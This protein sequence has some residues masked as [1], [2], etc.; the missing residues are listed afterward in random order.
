MAAQG[1]PERARVVVIGGGVGGA[2]IVHHLAARGETDVVL[3]ERS[4]LTSGSTFHSAGLVG[5]LRSSVTLT[6]LMM[7]SASLY[8]DLAA[9]PETDPGWVECGGLRLAS[10]PERM[11]E[12][13][14]QVAWGETFGLHLEQ[15][16]AAQ[17]ADLFPLM[18]T[19]G[20]L[21]A[22]YLATDGYL[23]PS[24]LTYALV[25]RARSAGIGIHERT[26]V[27]GI[28]VGVGRFPAVRS[29][30]TDRG[31][32]ECEVVVAAAGLYT[33][34]IARMVGVRVPIVPMSHQYVVTA[35]FRDV[36][37]G[38]GAGAGAPRLPTVRDPD[39]LVY[40]RQDGAGL[41]MGG[42]ERMS[43][44]FALGP[45]GLDRV[46]ADFNGRL[47][48]EEWDRLEEITANSVTRVPVMGD[49]EIRRVINGPEG[50]TPD[51]E[52]CLGPTP[53]DGF[54]V[55]AGFCA[56]GIAGA[57]AVGKVMADWVVDGDPGM[58][59]WEMDARRFGPQYRS[60]GY[61]LARVRENYETYYD[62]RY[63]GQE[64]EA[65][66]P[67][68]T[69][70][71]YPWHAANGASFGEKSGWERVNYYT[72][73]AAGGDAG[74]RPA[75]WA[76]RLWS[77]AI[78]VEHRATRERAGLFDESSF[79]KLE[80][81]G[82]GAAAL[83]DRLCANWV[84]RGPGRVTYTQ[85]LNERGGIE[86]D[87]TVSQVDDRTFMVVT[88]TALAGHD[89]AWI[90][91]HARSQIA[92]GSVQVRDV[93]SQWVC[94]G[95]WGP[96]ARDIL[97][98]LTPASLD[99]DAFGYLTL[100]EAPVGNAP[101]RIVRVTF[102][103][104]L[105]WEI[106]APTEYGAALWEEIW[107]AGAEH[108]LTACGY[109]AIDSLRAEKGYRYWGSDITGDESP[110]EAGL[111][112]AVRLERPASAGGARR[113]FIGR[114]ALDLQPEPKRRLACLTL[115]DPR[116][117][118]LGNE[119]VRVVGRGGSGRTASVAGE[120][121]GR[122]TSGALGYTVGSSIAFAYLPPDLAAVGTEVEVLVFGDW[123]RA[124]VATDGSRPLFD[125]EGTRIRAET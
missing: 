51:N 53:V 26:R 98:T 45:D 41:V 15:L 102:V 29:V 111:G 120:S 90:T 31:V 52:F 50:F 81:S 7:Y 86:C 122:V 14:R 92:D 91:R 88:G 19:D 76:G 78:E 60:S 37:A 71:A 115:D 104:E 32:I 79:G 43:K 77:P 61:T 72:G 8:R 117:V 24:Q 67:L 66:R 55:A 119:P 28:D 62:I 101:A 80:V 83:L 11:E 40:F 95:L 105:G 22:T 89:L 121:L 124:V 39:L 74:L 34:E 38:A 35:P 49:V 12:L 114:A 96:R 21:G 93:T 47:L 82:P 94:F 18:S 25:K 46:P 118:V 27:L 97:S 63:P 3:V 100:Q 1:L 42:Y 84:V 9:D 125:P 87:V 103:G 20:V 36:G 108:G 13:S 112:F 109:R 2:S 73:N 113:E 57:G 48:A 69:S 106:Y 5:Q 44:P 16:S 4:E 33:A 99:N 65:G 85:M 56:H 110:A 70:A 6:R 64:R 116:R 68:R 123:V 23:D 30:R 17:A 58:D 59:L 107:Q 54:W 75:G 10:S